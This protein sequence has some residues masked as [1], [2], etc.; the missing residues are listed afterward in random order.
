M[1]S[2]LNC[3]FAREVGLADKNTLDNRFLD[4]LNTP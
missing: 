3:N 2:A 1:I 4:N